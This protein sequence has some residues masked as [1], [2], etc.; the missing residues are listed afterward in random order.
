MVV[1][2][3]AGGAF[4][5]FGDITTLMVWQKGKVDFIEFF[6]IF[7]PSLVN[8]IIPAAIMSMAVSKERP[9]AMDEAIR[10]KLGAKRIIA[11]FML[12]IVDGRLFP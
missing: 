5:P 12:T 3:N 11:L 8:W 9:Q 10:M 4:S 6:A 2:A 1:G 7:F